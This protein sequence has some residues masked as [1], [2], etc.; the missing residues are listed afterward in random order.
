MGHVFGGDT[1]AAAVLNR[2]RIATTPS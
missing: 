1:I 2:I